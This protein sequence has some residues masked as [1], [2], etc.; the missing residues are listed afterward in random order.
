LGYNFKIYYDK[1]YKNEFISTPLSGIGTIGISN[2]A[3]ITIN[4]D[5]NIP[6]QL[7]YNLEKSGYISTSDKEVNN[8]SEILFVDSVYNSNYKISGVGTTT[9]NISLSKKPEKLTYT[10]NECD[11]LQYTTNSLSAK[12]PIDKINIISGGSGYKKL[13]IFK[14]SNSLAGKDAY[15]ISKSTSIGNAKEVRIIDEGFQYSSDKTLQPIAAISPLII[16]KNSNTIDSAI[17]TNGGRGYTDAPSIV[18]VNTETGEKINSGILEA[19]LSGNTINS[20]NIIQKP[21]GIP[22]T[23]VR[24]YATNN[25]NGIS[26]QKVE[27]N[28][29]GIFTCSITTPTLGFSTFVPYPFSVKDKVFVEGIQKSS[30]EG[31]WI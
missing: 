31:N 25:T 22:E 18:I 26:I 3:S 9:F 16:I 10:S 2:N 17:V 4:Y 27:S 21:K 28:S 19:T 15:I 5:D 29:T 14:G 7:Y 20:V 24:L 12:G 1:D 11:K 8:Y 30:I 6:T 13:P 23:A